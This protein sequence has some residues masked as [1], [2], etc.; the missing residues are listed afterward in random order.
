MLEMS[1]GHAI[2]G[3]YAPAVG[4]QIDVA[5][6]HRNHRL[7]GDAHGGFQ[8]RSVATASVVGHLRVFMHLAAYAVTCEFAHHAIAE[9][10]SVVL[11][12]SAD[13]THMAA[14]NSLFY[15]FIERCLCHFQQLFHIV[16]DFAHAERIAGVAVVA[17]EQRTT[18]Y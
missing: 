5:L 18:I 15:S 1:C 7:D 3:A 6:A 2:A 4:L 10:F 16:G 17:V 12:G 8:Q 9:A 13:I 11:H 14:G